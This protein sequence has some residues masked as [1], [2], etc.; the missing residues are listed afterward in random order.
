MLLVG[1]L[2]GIVSAQPT[3]NAKQLATMLGLEAKFDQLHALSARGSDG[4][5]ASMDQLLIRQELVE[6][7]QAAALD[8]D[9]VLAE[10]A[11]ERGQ[12]TELRF[13]LQTRRERTVNH[14]NAAALLTGSGL[15]AA[16]S[17]TQFTALG[18]R[19]QNVGDALGIASGVASTI[20]AVLAVRKQSG[21]SGTVG[22]TP[23][24]LAQ[25]LGGGAESVL[26]S[27]WPRPVLDYL[28][29]TPAGGQTRGTRLEQLL[30][31]WTTAG[32]LEAA[33]SAKRQRKITQL[34]TSMDSNVKITIEDLTD[35]IA[36]LTDVG[37]RVALMKRDLADLLRAC[38]GLR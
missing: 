35:R 11:N 20:F 17:A 21:P 13:S 10:L 3:G 5:T 34:T 14:L 18:S 38:S 31:Q 37:G 4:Q 19:T 29:S 2:S 22:R 33:D 28:G 30:E 36:M 6:S 12:L 15:S 8:V 26:N 25:L 23:N 7:V 9:S 16:V 24:M 32:R 1:S 27:S